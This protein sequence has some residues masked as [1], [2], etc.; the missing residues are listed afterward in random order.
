MGLE[1]SVWIFVFGVD[2][3]LIFLGQGHIRV[4]LREGQVDK[5]RD[6]GPCSECPSSRQRRG[7]MPGLVFSLL[8][9]GCHL[10]LS[11]GVS[12]PC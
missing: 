3:F 5:D 7:G 9:D 1:A 10:C 4:V 11:G 6:V 12:G 8:S 2:T